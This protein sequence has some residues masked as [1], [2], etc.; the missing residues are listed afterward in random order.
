MTKFKLVSEEE[1]TEMV[2]KNYQ[3][4]DL[5]LLKSGKVKKTIGNSFAVHQL[6]D[7]YLATFGIAIFHMVKVSNLELRGILLLDGFP[8]ENEGLFHQ[9]YG[10]ED[11]EVPIQLKG[12]DECSYSFQYNTTK[13]TCVLERHAWQQ[14]T[15][16]RNFETFKEMWTLVQEEGYS[17]KLF[18][19]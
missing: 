11:L 10:Y 13:K 6:L 4:A 16:Q 18:E 3:L 15:H 14:V 9:L 8:L 1:H 2:L 12:F 5:M 17:V 7:M 19:V